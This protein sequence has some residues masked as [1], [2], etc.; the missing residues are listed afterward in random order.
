MFHVKHST[1]ETDLLYNELSILGMEIDHSVI[2]QCIDYWNLLCEASVRLNVISGNAVKHGPMRHIV[3]SL[4]ALIRCP[5]APSDSLLD[6]GSGGGIPGLPLAI[7][8]PRAEKLLLEAKEKKRDWLVATIKR[9]GLQDRVT[10]VS[11][12]IEKWHISDFEGFETVTARA[13][14][15]PP[16]LFRWVLPALGPESQLL[17]WHSQQ[18]KDE[19]IDVLR[20]RFGGRL[21]E[22]NYTLSYA[23]KSINFSSHI[24]SISEA[25]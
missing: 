21:F 10:V 20:N 9:L 24:S 8:R 17:L 5:S 14:A 3:D 1:S 16:R 18:Q 25:R 13:V 22:L 12:R 7:A 23:Y 2:E 15:P 4:A 6:I 19:I 11:G